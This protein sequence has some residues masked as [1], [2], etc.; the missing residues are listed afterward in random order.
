VKNKV[1][2][3]ILSVA[4]IAGLVL[5]G[6]GGEAAP[7]DVFE[8]RFHSPHSEERTEYALQLDWVNMIYAATNGRLKVTIYPAGALGFKDADMLR[9][10]GLD[11]T[12]E[13]FLA[14]PN[15]VTRDEPTLSVLMPH[16][17]GVFTSREEVQKMMPVVIEEGKKIYAEW[18][19]RVLSWYP[20][21]ACYTG[22]ASVGP[23]DSIEALQG[24]KVRCYDVI[25]AAALRSLGI[26]GEVYPQADIYLNMKT[27]VSD[28]AAGYPT[29]V[30]NLSL[31]EVANYYS[32]FTVNSI[33]TGPAVNEQVFQ[34]LPADLQEIVLR[35]SKEHQE[36]YIETCVICLEDEGDLAWI[37]NETSVIVLPDWSDE[38]KAAFSAAA[39]AEWQAMA[40]EF[41]P[42]AVELQKVIQAELE[43]I[44]AG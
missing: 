4:L 31:Q 19:I 17:C 27:G 39:C 20:T 24:K 3:S 26:A 22:F 43:R 10:V 34:A 42:K 21:P 18:G 30:K 37:R 6:C 38:D 13:S 7:P 1:I 41:G 36:K 12:I 15:Y 40:V 9:V 5:V 44:R 2:M 32:L 29:M 33:V 23:C 8:W 16:G 14:C 28:A 11:A 35:V 25:Q